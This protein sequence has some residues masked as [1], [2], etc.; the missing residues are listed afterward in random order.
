MLTRAG[1]CFLAVLA[2][3][4]G[5]PSSAAKEDAI[6]APTGPR[7]TTESAGTI[8][9]FETAQRLAIERAAP[10]TLPRNLAPVALKAAAQRHF[11]QI[12]W[13]V[14]YPHG[15]HVTPKVTIHGKIIRCTVELTGSPDGAETDW[16][17]F[18]TRIDQL[19]AAS[20]RI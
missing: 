5:S 4:N 3:C 18:E 15:Q 13:A 7:V 14:A 1:I 8:E 16:A 9:R 10:N 20:Y 11:A 19:P 12:W 2:A 6:V 17:K